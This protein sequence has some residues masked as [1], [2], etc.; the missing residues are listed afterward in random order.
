MGFSLNYSSFFYTTGGPLYDYTAYTEV[1]IKKVAIT[2]NFFFFFFF[3]TW[4]SLKLFD[5][6][7]NVV[8]VMY[9]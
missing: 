9:K 8:V 1:Y 7:Q 6:F 3:F 2:I 4:A 5:F